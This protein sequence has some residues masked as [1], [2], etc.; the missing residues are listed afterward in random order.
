MRFQNNNALIFF[1]VC[2]LF[3]SFTEKASAELYMKIYG[4]VIDKESGLG[5]SST[6]VVLLAQRHGK[7]AEAT[8]NSKGDFILKKVKQGSYSLIAESDNQFIINTST[9]I[10]VFVPKG[11]NVVGALVKLEHG[12]AIKGRVIT[13]TGV[14]V[15]KANILANG[16]SATTDE[17]GNFHLKGIPAGEL[18]VGVFASGV[19]I[20]AVPAVIEKNKTYALGDINLNIGV[21]TSIQGTVVDQSGLPV[22]GAILVAY[23][24]RYS[25]GYTLNSDDGTFVLTGLEP[26]SHE[27]VVVAYGYEQ[28]KL[29]NIGIPSSNIKVVMSPSQHQTSQSWKIH[30]PTKLSN[31]DYLFNKFIDLITPQNAFALNSCNLG[32]CPEN[33]WWG[34]SA[35]LTGIAPIWVLKVAGGSFSIGRYFCRSSNARLDFTSFCELIGSGNT[36]FQLSASA[37]G[38][39]CR[40]ACCGEDLYGNTYGPYFSLGVGLTGGGGGIDFSSGATCYSVSGGL[41]FS[42][43]TWTDWADPDSKLWGGFVA[44]R[45]CDIS[46]PVNVFEWYADNLF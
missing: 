37:T 41:G 16:I 17:K 45:T 26:S 18:L 43:P 10:P 34:A 21:G 2:L 46:K 30:Y 15:P 1:T 22:P 14:A 38:Y 5:L 39:Y 42:T 29:K 25:A 36:T 28:I 40:K 9:P 44:Y 24:D 4:K 32:T 23:N 6:K 19:G 11:K 12:G 3:F 13:S 20:K 8:T 35:D 33:E 31:N 27:L 7:V